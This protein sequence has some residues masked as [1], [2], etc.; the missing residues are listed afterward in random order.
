MINLL[1]DTRGPD[2]SLVRS[3]KEWAREAMGLDVDAILTVSELRCM[4]EG[5]PEVET[6]IGVPGSGRPPVKVSKPMADV[7]RD[8]IVAAIAA[9]RAA[10]A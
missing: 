1:G 10:E 7:A 3:V 6:V 5:C 4:E 2:P 8:D 9:S